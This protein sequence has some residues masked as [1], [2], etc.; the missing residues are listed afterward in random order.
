MMI[1]IALPRYK[2]HLSKWSEARDRVFPARL[3][4]RCKIDRVSRSQRWESRDAMAMPVIACPDRGCA[5]S[6]CYKLILMSRR[7][8]GRSIKWP[9]T[10]SVARKLA[11]IVKQRRTINPQRDVVTMSTDSRTTVI[12]FA[13]FLTLPGWKIILATSRY[14]TW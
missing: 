12:I 1:F 2:V 7:A 4:P 14:T 8:I 10:I 9:S 5:I 13:P 3:Q 11:F 6:D